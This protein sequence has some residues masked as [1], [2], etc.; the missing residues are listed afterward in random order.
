MALK[1]QYAQLSVDYQQQRLM[2]MDIRSKMGDD[3]CARSF[4]RFVLGRP[5]S[6][7]SSS[8]FSSVIVL[9]YFFF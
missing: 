5:T 6:T 3:T 4:G 1:Q 2:V 9:V 8:F 7:I